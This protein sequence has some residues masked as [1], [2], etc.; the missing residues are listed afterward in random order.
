MDSLKELSNAIAT[1]NAERDWD[2]FHSPENLAKS[3]SIEANEL[4]ECFQWSSDNYSMEEVKSE[5][6]D[7]VTYC[8]QMATK[9]DLDIKDIVLNN[10][11]TN[12][13]VREGM[14]YLGEIKE[15][16]LKNVVSTN[17][18]LLDINYVVDGTACVLVNKEKA[19]KIIK[20]D[21]V[22]TPEETNNE[23]LNNE[24]N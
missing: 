1:F 15:V 6:A 21:W 11:N 22:Y 23:T 9:L 5:L 24:Q 17:M 16:D 10:T 18:P 13:T 2:Q 12:I 7:V 8:I 19:R 14:K 3:I 4:L 20:E